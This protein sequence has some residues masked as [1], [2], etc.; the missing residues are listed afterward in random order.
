MTHTSLNLNPLGGFRKPSAYTLLTGATGLLGQY[1]L[2]ELIRGGHQVAVLARPKSTLSARQ[3]IE[4]I[5]QRW[6]RYHETCLPRPVIV[7]GDITHPEHLGMNPEDRQWVA[8]HVGRILHNAAIIRFNGSEETEPWITNCRGTANVIG[9]AQANGIDDFCHISSAYV[10]GLQDQV[11]P[12]LP[13]VGEPQFRNV[14]EQSKYA[15]EQLVLNSGLQTTVFR[16]AVIVGD[17][18]TGFT[19]SY[20]GLFAYLRLMSILIPERERDERGVIQTPMR[21]PFTGTERRNLVTVDWVARVI[22]RVVSNPQSRGKIFHLTPEQAPTSREL[23]EYCYEYFNSDGVRFADVRSSAETEAQT[24][25]GKK[26]L[27]GLNVYHAYDTS[28]PQFDRSNTEQFAGD[29]PCPVI[30]RQL[31]HRFFEFGENDNWGKGKSQ[32]P[33]VDLWAEDHLEEL[34]AVTGLGAGAKADARLTRAPSSG[35]RPGSARVYLDILG[36]GGGQ[37]TISF[38][39]DNLNI[40]KGWVSTP[41]A[42]ATYKFRATSRE[43]AEMLQR[44]GQ[45]VMPGGISSR[46]QPCPEGAVQVH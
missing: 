23:I 21:A 20:H 31:V 9:V 3:R 14:Y 24:D 29:I 16:P 32:A 38:E 25:F 1:I 43:V 36:P 40:T 45:G 44:T 35:R 42:G 46:L 18:E 17:S 19:C 41:Q 13:M 4:R 26:F 27:S 28:D 7:E 6:D 5:M 8:D 39:R 22:E 11:V 12:E 2:H 33:A 34:L 37:W 10:C 30:D 15:A